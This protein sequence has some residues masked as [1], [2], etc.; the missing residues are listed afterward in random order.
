MV[1]SLLPSGDSDAVKQVEALAVKLDT[2][3]FSQTRE[4]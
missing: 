1:G 2:L 3:K 4:D